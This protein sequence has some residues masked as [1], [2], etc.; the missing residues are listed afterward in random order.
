MIRLNNNGIF[1]Y[2]TFSV[3]FVTHRC[4]RWRCAD[5]SYFLGFSMEEI[6]AIVTQGGGGGIWQSISVLCFQRSRSWF[7]D[8]E[9]VPERRET[10]MY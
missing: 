9:H 1:I 2:F 6:R 4:R 5:V 10:G 8:V 3:L 7:V